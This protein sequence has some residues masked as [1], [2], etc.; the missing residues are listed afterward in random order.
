MPYVPPEFRSHE[1]WGPQVVPEGYC[2][3]LGDNR[4]NSSDSRHWGFVPNK[5]IIGRVLGAVWR[6]R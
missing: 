6:G 3:V 2:F 1:G 5:Y 4:N